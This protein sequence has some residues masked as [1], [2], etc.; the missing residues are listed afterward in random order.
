MTHPRPTTLPQAGPMMLDRSRPFTRRAALDAG[1]TRRQLEGRDHRRLLTGVYVGA[2]VRLGPDVWAAAALLC[3]P[4]DARASHCSAARVWGVPVP[5]CAQEHVTVSHPRD[6]RQRDGIRC[7]LGA[8][9]VLP[10]IVDGVRVTALPELF[11]ELADELGLVDLVVVGDWMLRRR[12]ITVQQL[13]AAVDA[14]HGDGR[15]RAARALSHVRPRVDSPMETR[16]RML[17][18]LAGVPEPDINVTIRTE[19]GE[20]IRRYDLSWPGVRVIVEYDGRHHAEREE[21]WERDLERREAIDDDGWRILVVVANGIYARPGHTVD[22]V[23]R[24]LRSRGLPGL[25]HRPS[26]A[27][28]PHFPGHAEA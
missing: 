10:R 26:E 27:W 23:W 19:D 3:F 12:G 25:P 21:T 9:D 28:R 5:T 2:S 4:A 16:L 13:R 8:P 18:V 11:V 22:R 14:T 20:P 1:M 7:H 24:L 17:L 6:R 15:R